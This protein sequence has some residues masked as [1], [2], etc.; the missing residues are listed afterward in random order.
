[1]MPTKRSLLAA[2]IRRD[3]P[4]LTEDQAD[5]AAACALYSLDR[6]DRRERE[7]ESRTAP[8]PI[9]GGTAV[10][11]GDIT[12]GRLIQRYADTAPNGDIRAPMPCH[13]DARVTV[14]RGQGEEHV[15]VCPCG[16][17]YDLVVEAEWDGGYIAN[18]TLAERQFIK[19]RKRRAA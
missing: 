6:V 18:F 15:A 14:R 16:R 5:A 19:A 2:E 8:P 7:D 3:L 17:T 13:E 1:M 12:T 11:P 4:E 10:Q 9:D